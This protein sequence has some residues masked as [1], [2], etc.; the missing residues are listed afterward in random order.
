MQAPIFNDD[1]DV[2][3]VT[4]TP[5]TAP[6]SEKTDDLIAH[7][8]RRRRAGRDRLGPRRKAYVSGQNAAFIDISDRILER[9]PWF[10]LYIIGVTFIVLAM[11]FRSAVIALKAAITTLLSA[12]VG[13]GVLTFV[14]RWATGSI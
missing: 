10:L 13:F 7:A 6:Q 4:I 14:L 1:K 3:L 8:A 11:A 12:I 5:A 9:A 2:G